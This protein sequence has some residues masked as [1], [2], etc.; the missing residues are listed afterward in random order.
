[1]SLLRRLRKP[2]FRRIVFF[3]FVGW[4][5]LDVVRFHS[6][7]LS[8]PSPSGATGAPKQRI[9]IASTHWNNEQILKNHWNSAVLQLVKYFGPNDTFV[10]VY[11][12]G[13]WDNSKAVL[14]EL[15][16]ELKSIGV[17]HEI[18]LDKVTHEDVIAQPATHTGWI[19]TPRDKKELR[20]IPYL[21]KLRN[22]SLEPLQSL[23]QQGI[24]FDKVLFLNDVVFTIDDVLT[25]LGTNDGHYA[26]TCS[27]DFSRPPRFYDTFA[28]RDS[29]GHEA[30][31]ST[32]PYFRSQLSRAAV[33]RGDP[34]PVS[35]CWNGMVFMKSEPFYSQNNALRFRGI[36]DTLALSHLEA[37]E[38]C[39]IHQDNPL[40][41]TEGV[42]VNPL[43][44]VGYSKLAYDTMN[45]PGGE[46]SLFSYLHRTWE[47]RLLR[48][49]TTDWFKKRV[50]KR[51]HSQWQSSS[52][53]RVETGVNC[54]INEMQVLVGNGWAHV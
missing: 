28:L 25:L 23:A 43:V 5:F 42:F 37:S 44:K 49:A 3:L 7:R 24:F 26:A 34:V 38:C 45:G 19:H 47:N 54:L 15:Q 12:S 10:S 20:R 30:I 9:Y 17:G 33:K 48:W 51:R 31:M 32:W 27:L 14:R 4:C 21:S 53:T 22:I 2:W 18:V 41:L 29:E 35:S 13:S 1:M 39:L 6:L 8:T 50:V 36:P 16:T 40:S 52:R 11:E 46:L